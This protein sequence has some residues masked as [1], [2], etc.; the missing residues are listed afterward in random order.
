MVPQDWAIEVATENDRSL[1][2]FGQGHSGA[3]GAAD[4]DF[5]MIQWEFMGFHGDFQADSM[6]FH[7]FFLNGNM[8]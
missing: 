7:V 2:S 3:N 4:G 5:W 1:V 6:G 8:I